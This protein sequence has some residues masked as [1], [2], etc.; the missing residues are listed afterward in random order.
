MRKKIWVVL[1]LLVLSL[2][3]SARALNEYEVWTTYYDCAL[4]GVGG[5]LRECDNGYWWWQ[6]Q[7]GAFKS[8]ERY[9]CNGGAAGPVNWYA[10]DGSSWVE[11][12]GAPD[13]SC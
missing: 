2:A 7:S 10:W 11:L 9:S 1:V 3:G 6:Q 12:P 13:P 8:V 4:N 5:S